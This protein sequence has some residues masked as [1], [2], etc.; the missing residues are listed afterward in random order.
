MGLAGLLPLKAPG[1]L[2]RL[3]SLLI[4]YGVRLRVNGF[5][6]LGTWE[7]GLVGTGSGRGGLPL[8]PTLSRARSE[9]R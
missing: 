4:L 7:A 1:A 2:H 8:L 5:A 6:R 3:G 9:L